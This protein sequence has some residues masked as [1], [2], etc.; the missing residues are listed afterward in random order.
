[1]FMHVQQIKSSHKTL[2]HAWYSSGS[3]LLLDPDAVHADRIA[4]VNVEMHLSAVAT[5]PCCITG[6]GWCV[7]W[8][9]LNSEEVEKIEFKAKQSYLSHNK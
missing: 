3:A 8:F 5:N 9:T 1:M 4:T 2:T 7:V 6:I